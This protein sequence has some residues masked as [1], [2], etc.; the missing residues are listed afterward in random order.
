MGYVILQA[1][2]AL[3]ATIGVFEVIWHGVL[4]CMRRSLRCRKARILLFAE[5]DTDPVLVT[6]QVGFWTEQ[7]A[8]NDTEVWVLCAPDSPQD[9]RCRQIAGRSSAVQVLSPEEAAHRLIN[10]PYGE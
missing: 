4:F 7:I 5:E 1:L 3:F 8:G 10:E 9:S 6:E 2:T